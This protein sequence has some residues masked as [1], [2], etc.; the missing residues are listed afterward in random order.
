M[1]S[2]APSSICTWGYDRIQEALKNLGIKLSD[3]T[4][5]NILSEHGIEPAPHRKRKTTWKS[6]L[7]SHWDVMGAA[8]FTTVEVWT[9]RGLVTF[10]ILVAMRLSTRRVEIARV[11]LNPDA[12]W[13]QQ[14]GRNLTDCYDEFLNDTRYLLL[15]LDIG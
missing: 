7:K 6:F 12:A 13:V 14:A 3:T 2:N 8:A 11:T 5:A 4:V 1:S 10:Y 15:D 9:C